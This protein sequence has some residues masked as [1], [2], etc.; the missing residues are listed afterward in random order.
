ML[1]LG[2]ATVLLAP[3]LR[4]TLAAAVPTSV[5]HAIIPSAAVVTLE[6][7]RSSNSGPLEHTALDLEVFESTTPC[8]QGNVTLNGELL[9]QD[10]L[11]H[12]SGSLATN[13]GSILGASWKFTCVHLER[14]SQAQLLSVHIVSVDGYDVDDFAFSVQFRQ[15]APVTIYWVDGATVRPELSPALDPPS[16]PNPSLENEL[17]DLEVLQEQ[18]LALEHSIA[19]KVAHISN[20]FDLDQPGKSLLADCDSLKCFFSTIYDQMKAMAGKV[21]PGGQ[22]KQHDLLSQLGSTRWL[23]SH[24][25]QQPLKET[26]EKEKLGSPLL[27]E[28]PVQVGSQDKVKELSSIADKDA[29]QPQRQ[30]VDSSHQVRHVLVL[31][32]VILAIAINLT[33][34]VLMFQCVRLLRQ[35]RKAR[36]E[37]RRRQLRKSR[38]A[39]N[40]LVATKYLDLIQWLRDGMGRESIEDEEKNAMMRRL[41]ESDSDEG[42]SSDTFS[43]TMEEEI[44]QFRA[45]AGF[46]GSLVAEGGRGRDRLTNHLNLT[47]PRRASTPSSLSSSMSSCP[48]YRSVDE[49]LPAYDENRSPEYAVDG[50]QY[51]PSSSTPGTSSPRCSTPDSLTTCSS[52]DEDVEK[53]D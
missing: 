7:G 42:E 11:G 27:P 44:A 32:A 51:T 16:N 2:K 22:Q 28:E 48:T 3:V 40:T 9:D 53:K 13:S 34:M 36:W 25:G 5:S 45:A 15:T 4:L 31:I 29:G 14:D 23:S 10:S 18:L 46:V 41:H 38:D 12:G 24:G 1:G 6:L 17:A 49:S 52:L 35:R 30:I 33:I 21:Y 19:L 47:R 20:N 37:K 8:G 26:D 39:C 43:I 50:L